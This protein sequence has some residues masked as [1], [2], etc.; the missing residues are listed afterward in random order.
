M[1]KGC[2]LTLAMHGV[3]RNSAY[4]RCLYPF[5]CYQFQG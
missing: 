5:G 3:N 2:T 1:A 4:F